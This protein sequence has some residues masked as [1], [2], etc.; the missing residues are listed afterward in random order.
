MIKEW[1]LN[2]FAD[3]CLPE[4]E[5]H[6]IEMPYAYLGVMTVEEQVERQLETPDRIIPCFSPLDVNV[7]IIDFQGEG[8]GTGLIINNVCLSPSLFD[9][10]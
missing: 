5:K 3:S 2:V 10:V 1:R 7:L 6:S 8:V 9:A 4:K